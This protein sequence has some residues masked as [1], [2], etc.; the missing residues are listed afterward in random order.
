MARKVRFIAGSSN[1]TV[2]KVNVVTVVTT[3]AETIEQSLVD[4]RIIPTWQDSQGS[5][6]GLKTV[7]VPGYV[8]PNNTAPTL[9]LPTGVATGITT[10]TVGVTTNESAGTLYTVVSTNNTTPTAAQIIAG[11]DGTAAAGAYAGSLTP[12]AGINTFS[13]TGLAGATVY[14]AFF[15]H[16]DSGAL[17]SNV[18]GASSFTTNTDTAFLTEDGLDDWLTEDG[19]DTIVVEG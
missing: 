14:Y 5:V 2:K 3:N 18:I 1:L 4:T 8:T 13:A 17:D 19:A 10:A 11:L 7:Y 12:T 16:H 15:V 6:A 9:S